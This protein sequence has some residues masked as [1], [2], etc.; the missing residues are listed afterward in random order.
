MTAHDL[1]TELD[2]R[3]ITLQ[4]HGDRLRYSPRSAVTPDLAGR[5]KAHKAA[6]LAILASEP[7]EPEVSQDANDANWQAIRDA[8]R[9]HLLGPRNWPAPCSW[10]GG[11]LIH[12]AACNELRQEW[13]PIMPFG[14]HRG[15]RVD[16]LPADYIDWILIKGV[17]DRGFLSDLRRWREAR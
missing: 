8:D 1:L 4:A 11:R 17:G 13:V 2:R 10:C 15:R 5:M 16:E 3:G 14:K 7:W 12:R 6:L 9:K